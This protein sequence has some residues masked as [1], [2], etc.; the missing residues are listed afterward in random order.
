MD[1]SRVSW[2]QRLRRR[3]RLPVSR[4]SRCKF[5]PSGST[6]RR[7]TTTPGFIPKSKWIRC[8]FV[9][10]CHSPVS[11]ASISPTTLPLVTM[12]ASDISVMPRS[13]S[14]DRVVRSGVTNERTKCLTTD[15]FIGIGQSM[16]RQLYSST[17]LDGMMN[18]LLW[19]GHLHLQDQ[20][21]CT[22]YSRILVLHL[23]GGRHF[24]FPRMMPSA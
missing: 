15:F 12:F 19:I 9:K 4:H 10:V 21:S 20:S 6:A 2:V 18:R 23:I 11:P 5:M 16:E 13:R 17:S 22:P 14:P 7:R 24:L 1:R 3:R 8:P